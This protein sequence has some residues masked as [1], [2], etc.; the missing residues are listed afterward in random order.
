VEKVAI[1]LEDWK[2]EIEGKV[3]NIELEVGKL[4]K[5]WE[6]SACERT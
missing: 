6:R 1:E 2:P 3:D 5:H 4:T